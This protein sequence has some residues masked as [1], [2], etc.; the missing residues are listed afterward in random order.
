MHT[1]RLELL[2]TSVIQG[3]RF[4][5]SC[6]RL[7][8]ARFRLPAMSSYKNYSM[9]PERLLVVAGNILAKCVLEAQRADAKRIFNDIQDGKRASLV[10]VR[11]DDETEVRFDLALDHSEFR[12]G[13]LNYRAFRNSL[14]GLVQGLGENLKREFEVPVFT[15][16]NSG[17]MLFAIPGYTEVEGHANVMMLSINLREPGCVQVKLM[18]MDPDQFTLKQDGQD[19]TG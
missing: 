8:G 17:T 5:R 10:N 2:P 6:W 14:A 3:R 12:G 7:Q 13:R 15:D 1:N 18:Y 4:T 11:M 9:P 19:A 16:K